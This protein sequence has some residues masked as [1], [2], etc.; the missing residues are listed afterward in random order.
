MNARG[1]R[2]RNPQGAVAVVVGDVA[3]WLGAKSRDLVA[4]GCERPVSPLSRLC[5]YGAKVEP[6]A[7][8]VKA[9]RFNTMATMPATTIRATPMMGEAIADRRLR[10][11][12]MVNTMLKM[13][14]IVVAMGTR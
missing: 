6:I 1:A 12:T 2:K 14:T 7:G 13:A 11:R 4:F 8:Y 5:N 3:P 9:F 10:V